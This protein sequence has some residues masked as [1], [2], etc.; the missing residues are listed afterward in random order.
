MGAEAIRELLTRSISTSSR[1]AAGHREDREL[2]PAEEETLKR[3]R[4]VE[5][6]RQRREQ[7][8]SG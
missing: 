6:F 5:A 7:A 3:L 2:G 8:G 1:G 4:I